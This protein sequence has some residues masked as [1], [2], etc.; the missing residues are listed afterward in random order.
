M[1]M[2]GFLA[3]CQYRLNG[4]EVAGDRINTTKKGVT[5]PGV[6]SELIEALGL[7]VGFH[8]NIKRLMQIATRNRRT[9]E[10]LVKQTLSLRCNIPSLLHWP[11]RWSY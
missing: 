6:P 4:L 7:M 9:L 10:R 11:I 5:L 8:V 3:Q 1:V 2:S